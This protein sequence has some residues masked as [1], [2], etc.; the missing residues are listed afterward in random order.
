VDQDLRERFSSNDLETVLGIARELDAEGGQVLLV[1]G[2]VRDAALDLAPKDLDLEV[3]GIQADHLRTL[4]A[5]GHGLDEVGKSFGILKLKNS[6][7]EVSLPRT[8]TKAGMGHKGFEVE[9]D[10]QLPFPE[11]SA[12][13]DF[14]IN[15]MG[16]DPLSGE[17]L[18]PHGGRKDL[19]DKVLRHVGPAFVEDPLRVLRGMQFVA[20]MQLTAE[21]E[22]IALCSTIDLEELPRERIFE[23]WRKLILKG[24][25]ISMGLRF[26]QSTTW[27][28]F[29]PELEALV[30]CPQDPEWHP[31][32]DVW[33]HTLHCMDAFSK[34]RVDDDW[35]NLVV[36][37]AVLCHDFG[38]PAT[39]VVASDG[40]IRSPKHEHEGAEIAR[41]FLARM[42]NHK[43][44]LEQVI[45]LVRRHLAPHVF[46]NDQAG[47]GAIRRLAKE[48]TRI[49]RLVRVATAD[50]AGRP[51]KPA[52]FPEGN[53]LLE[54]AEALK[55][56]DSA[57]A[58][59]V[60]GRHLIKRGL[61]A[62]PG[63]KPILDKCFEA[64]LDGLFTDL[65]SGL[66][67]LSQVLEKNDSN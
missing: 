41:C 51:P 60:Q 52:E 47:D 24:K 49:D 19:E 30:D 65:P 5:R 32:G 2:C 37:L 26:L 48:V 11:A 13:R 53:W 33:I 10:P 42:T 56:K 57:P 43:D 4:L 17:L 21:P 23:E 34:L 46:H 22:T 3:R 7:I 28:R 8:E 66:A 63:F 50:M 20:R 29:F 58:P 55:V 9:V 25:S 61:P 62:G 16:L 39:T 35:E 45:P 12:R 59:I 14:T 31:E 64:Q 18:D 15:A 38:K 40:R 1:G 54:R 44:L 6:P 27:L 36:G 67:Y